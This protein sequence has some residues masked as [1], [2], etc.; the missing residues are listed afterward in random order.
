M[1]K[2]P[3]QLQ[4]P[5]G[6]ESPKSRATGPRKAPAPPANVVDLAEARRWLRPEIRSRQD[7]VGALVGQ[8]AALVRGTT[9]AD[10]A[11]EVRKAASRALDLFEA[12]DRGKS[13]KG[14]LGAA[15]K[16]VE[17]LLKRQHN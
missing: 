12:A 9:T 5:F 14:E 10:R 16:R 17:D 1:P 11:G 4:L 6:G 7:V 8:L 13:T 15:L 2:H 3:E